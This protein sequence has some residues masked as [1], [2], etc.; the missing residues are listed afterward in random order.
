M[1]YGRKS[2]GRRLKRLTSKGRWIRNKCKA[3]LLLLVL[4]VLVGG[5]A[6]VG[7]KGYDYVKAIIA[8]APEIT[9]EDASP[10]GYMST[11]YDSDGNVTA[12]LVA[13]GSNRVYV[14][15][16]EIPENLQNAFVAIED[17][18]FYEHNGIDVKG[19]IRAA[20][21]GVMSGSLSE[22]ASTITQQ[23]IKNNVFD[24]WTSETT[25]EKITRKI[26]EQYLAIQLE[27]QVS[28]EWILENYLNTIN[29][30]QNSLGVQA[31]SNRYFGKEVSE[32]TL[33]ECAVIA[34]I[35]Q[36]P[37]KYNPISNPEANNERRQ[38]VLSNMKEQGFITAEEYEEAMADDEVYERISENNQTY[39]SDTTN[40]TSY[41]VDALTEQVIEDLQ[42]VLG[43][44][45][46]Q[47]YN[48]LYSGG[49]EI[50]STQDSSI[51]AICD[52][53]INNDSNYSDISKKISFSYALSIQDDE[54]NVANYGEQTLLTWMKANDL[55][56]NLNFTSEE[57]AQAM[58]DEY[59]E[60]LLLE[61]GTV[62][63]ENVT[64]T[65]QPQA[66]MT[67]ID[68]TTGEV[69]ALVGGRGEKT[70]S[71][72][73]N[74]AS[75]TTM[76]PGSTF[77]ILTTYA[78]ALELGLVSL[79]TTVD[80]EE[81]SYASGQVIKNASGSYG[82]ATT[83]REAIRRS[84]NVV[85]IKVSREVTLDTCYQYALDFGITTLTED[86]CV[87]ALPLGGIT[88]GVTNLELTA[89]Y[90]AIAN[91][92]VYN[93]PIL[94]T[95]IIDHD[96]NVLIDK[97]EIAESHRVISE[98]TA[99]LLTSAMQDVVSSGTGAKAGFSGMSIAGKTGT[100]SNSR[101]SW[102]VGYTPYYT[103][104]VWGGYDDNTELS[105]TAFTK[106]LWR[107]A[108]SQIHSGLSN[109]GFTKPSGISSA[110]ICNDSGLLAGSSC[111]D[112]ATEYFASDTMPTETCSSHVT[113]DI[114]TESG[115][116][117]NEYCPN[118]ETTSF[119]KGDDEDEDSEI[120]T[121]TCTIHNEETVV[122]ENG[123]IVSV[124]T[125]VT[126]NEDGTTTTTTTTTRKKA[127]S[128]SSE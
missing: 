77:K 18:R 12:Q 49:L 122:D 35:T 7:Q 100:T 68:Q 125:K 40:V 92:G 81:I 58:I 116:L 89:A 82:G 5:V 14:T 38:K 44:S 2:A 1:N 123:E 39:E 128:S 31:A 103:C 73:L 33:S 94:Y 56:S 101:A 90:A 127:S 34:A 112:T 30:G 11:V 26:Q 120:P 24:N 46:T 65:I 62:L 29:L 75:D 110:T 36:N 85:A 16:D 108:M 87:E 113:V 17:E 41:F 104:A 32:L 79:A 121:E 80:D 105:S 48:A 50:Y 59:R 61:G 71:K 25:E 118:V 115:L 66:S 95:K 83:V 72:T 76:Q 63:G 99:W 21:K 45:E 126:T 93:E 86:D 111:T 107:S 106:V 124:T 47:A 98:A 51:Q 91:G 8:D 64:F 78:P 13:S 119:L 22:G 67:V 6:Y 96:G 84:I 102:F 74:R 28:K 20:A 117:A 69:K 52:S 15:I 54:G 53:V 97:T 19:I 88:D 27:K 114:C 3:I 109:T 23:L 57:A 70:A 43:Y 9:P 42:T 60:S 4:L 55:G 37:S 10:T